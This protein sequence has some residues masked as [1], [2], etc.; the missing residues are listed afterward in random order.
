MHTK[1]Q[2]AHTW[3]NN[4]FFSIYLFFPNWVIRF[5]FVLIALCLANQVYEHGTVAIQDF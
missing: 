3:K 4:S 5:V 1:L 2:S